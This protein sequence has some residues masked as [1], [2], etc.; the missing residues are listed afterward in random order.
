[1]FPASHRGT[2]F[3]ALD[4]I[5][6]QEEERGETFRGV[7]GRDM[8]WVVVLP[9]DLTLLFETVTCCYEKPWVI[10]R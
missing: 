2:Q 8:G 10:L 1:M 4:G 9:Q 5:E 7:E 3:E 6:G